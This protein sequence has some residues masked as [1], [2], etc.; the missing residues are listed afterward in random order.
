MR[1]LLCGK[2]DPAGEWNERPQEVKYVFYAGMDE[3]LE[4]VDRG[5]LLSPET[6]ARLKE[7]R[8][9]CVGGYVPQEAR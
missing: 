8:P 3:C 2:S 9:R 6:W 1:A 7:Y 4:A 5:D